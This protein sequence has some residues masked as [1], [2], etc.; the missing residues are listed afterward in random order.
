[1]HWPLLLRGSGSQLKSTEAQTRVFELPWVRQMFPTKILDYDSAGRI[2]DILIA[3]PHGV[4]RM[5]R[6]V[7][8]LVETSTNLAT[9]RTAAGKVEIQTTQRSSS[10][11]RL[12]AIAERIAAAARLS[13]ASVSSESGYL[14]WEPRTDSALLQNSI[15]VYRDLYKSEPIVEIIHAGLE[16][17]VIGEKYPEMEMLS[18]GPTIQMPHSPDERLNLPSLERLWEFL[19]HLLGA[20]R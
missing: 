2:L 6:D 5:S 13:G 14:P 18:I 16:C 7:A 19:V 1:M 4:I 8:N 20:L 11:S 3:L 9:V 12:K 15:E 17:G 10:E